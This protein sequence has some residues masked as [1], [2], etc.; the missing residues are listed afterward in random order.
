MKKFKTIITI[1]IVLFS[2]GFGNVFAQEKDLFSMILIASMLGN[3]N[4]A[5]VSQ[6]F[7]DRYIQITHK[8]SIKE[9]TV[10]CSEN[11][12]DHYEVF[13]FVIKYINDS[14][15][16][17]KAARRANT[18][19]CDLLSGIQYAEFVAP[20]YGLDDTPLPC[21]STFKDNF[22]KKGMGIVEISSTDISSLK[23]V[24]GLEKD[25]P[26]QVYVALTCYNSDMEN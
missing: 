15:D 10:W 9:Y 8:E 26:V 7:G 3:K 6:D 22:I 2:I 21:C 25:I 18:E 1:V 16:K 24:L 19:Y 14:N 17:Y 4:D 20:I 13:A 11:M 12:G 23:D 5:I